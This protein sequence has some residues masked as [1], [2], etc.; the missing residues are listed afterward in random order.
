[1]FVFRI[2]IAEVS[3]NIVIVVLVI[4]QSIY[5][6]SKVDLRI[7]LVIWIREVKISDD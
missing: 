6:C 2:G 1:M 4:E 5:I 7:Y 3:I